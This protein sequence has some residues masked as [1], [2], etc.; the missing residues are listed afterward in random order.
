MWGQ[1]NIFQV[2]WEGRTSRH[3]FAVYM[4]LIYFS[5]FLCLFFWGETIVTR[6]VLFYML[7][8]LPKLLVTVHRLHD[9]E[10]SGAIALLILLIPIPFFIVG[11]G[12][13]LT[14]ESLLNEFFLYCTMAVQSIFYF[15]LLILPGHEG[16]NKYGQD[17][18]QGN[19]KLVERADYPNSFVFDA[20][21]LRDVISLSRGRI[22][23]V[24]FENN[25]KHIYFYSILIT[26]VLCN[27]FKSYTMEMDFY[28]ET[29][30]A[31]FMMFALTWWGVSFI[32]K[33]YCI[34]K[35]S[36]DFG[37]SS[38]RGVVVVFV[39]LLSIGLYFVS[40]L[41]GVTF[42]LF[43]LW[44]F[45]LMPFYYIYIGTKESI[46]G[47]NLYGRL[48]KSERD[49]SIYVINEDGTITFENR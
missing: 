4:F 42:I 12:W 21:R 8:F 11:I 35:R 28:K 45:V 18:R 30:E 24:E 44:T 49:K 29:E 33:L 22:S 31:G 25:M 27:L 34:V 3:L 36:H 19:F 26:F 13:G 47:D 2:L 38:L 14:D 23:K 32:P 9:F 37:E 20:K 5:G 16:E 46:T 15:F 7:T 41:G 39:Q 17:P 40:F 1:N 6:P 10:A 48:P 43:M